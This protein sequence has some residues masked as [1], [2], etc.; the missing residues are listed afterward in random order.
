MRRASNSAA[1]ATGQTAGPGSARRDELRRF[2]LSI[3]RLSLSIFVAI[4]LAGA[5]T[6]IGIRLTVRQ[7]TVPVPDLRGLA[8]DEALTRVSTLGL[9]LESA[10]RDYSKDVPQG[11]IMEQIPAPNKNVKRGR[12]VRVIVSLGAKSKLAPN[13]IGAPL[14]QATTMLE[15]MGLSAG[16]VVTIPRAGVSRGQV[17]A[18]DPAPGA[19]LADRVSVH[20]LVS[21]GGTTEL[22]EMPDL[23]G[24]NLDQ[25][26]ARLKP[27]GLYVGGEMERKSMKDVPDGTIIGQDPLAGYPVASG[28]TVH[29]AVSS[30]SASA[31]PEESAAPEASEP[32][33]APE[34]PVEEQE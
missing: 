28:Q 32:A 7:D 31:A 26:E 4:A 2:L 1:S 21:G 22:W 8:I 16:D 29:V 13:L 25:A 15:G 24:G 20:M 27:F 10:E 5:A 14:R 11:R 12:A 17:L 33:A 3:L 23:I 34:A 18:Q 30:W 19:Q 6:M 9:L